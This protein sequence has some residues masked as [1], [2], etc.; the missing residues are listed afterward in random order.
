[1]R[2]YLKLTGALAKLYLRDPAGAFFT[3]AFAPLF[4]LFIG[5]IAGNDPEPSLSGMGYLD[6]NLPVFAAIVVGMVGL[7]SVP[8]GTVTL[9]ESG[10]LR[11]FMATPLRPLVYIAADVT[12]Y[13]V[14]TLIGIALAFVTGMI[15]FG[16]RLQGD[17]FGLFAAICL[18]ALA[19]MALG[20]TLASIEPTA[21]TAIVVGNVLAFPSLALSGATVPL[22]VLPQEAQNVARV[23]PLT[24]MV[25]LFR[26]LWLGEGW[27][28]YLTH[29]AVLGGMLVAGTALAAWLFRWE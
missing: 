24:Q 15:V 28:S 1:M 7:F 14:M 16:V 18:G 29:L 5:A 23:L 8:I 11:R 19:F 4:V 25:D 6:A 12:V 2:A 3:L 22:E 13:L 17:V 21:Q 27:Q 26:G 20:Y 10:A 9:R